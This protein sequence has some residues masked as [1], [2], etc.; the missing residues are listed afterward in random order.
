MSTDV[1]FDQITKDDILIINTDTYAK[2][3]KGGYKPQLDKL[4]QKGLIVLDRVAPEGKILRV[5]KSAFKFKFVP[6]L[7]RAKWIINS[8]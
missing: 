3:S 6:K 8:F 2:F 4:V 7:D 5:N 1:E